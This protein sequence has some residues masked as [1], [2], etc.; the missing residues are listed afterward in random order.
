MPGGTNVKEMEAPVLVIIN[1]MRSSKLMYFLY[2]YYHNTLTLIS[3]IMADLLGNGWSR[4]S[5][6]F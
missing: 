3:L 5:I 1:A 2:E 4:Y 6:L